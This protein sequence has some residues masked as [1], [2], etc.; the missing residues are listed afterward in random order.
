MATATTT[1]SV[2]VIN[3]EMSEQEA[4]A[5]LT[6][7]G[8]VGGHPTL[9]RRGLIDSIRHALEDADVTPQSGLEGSLEF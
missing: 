4:D 2:R 7:L 8:R 1:K 5:L 6:V 9:S 3:L